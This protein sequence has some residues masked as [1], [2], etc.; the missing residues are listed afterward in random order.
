VPALPL[1]P[2]APLEPLVPDEPLAPALPLVPVAP[3]PAETT[4]SLPT[5]VICTLV[6]AESVLN[7][8][9]PF[10]LEEKTLPVPPPMF[11]PLYGNICPNGVLPE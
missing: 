7:C 2:F 4:I 6:P 11:E 8:R 10:D 1:V 3:E 9:S 5:V